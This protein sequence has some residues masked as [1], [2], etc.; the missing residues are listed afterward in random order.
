MPFSVFGG[1][2]TLPAQ[3]SYASYSFAAS[4]TLLWPT[5]MQDTSYP[6]AFF[7]DVSASAGGLS[8]TMPNATQASPG[9]AVIF[10]NYGS[11]SISVLDAASGS[12]FT[13]A[14][15]QARYLVL[16][17]NATAAGS[18][19]IVTFGTGTSSADASALA[20]RG[21]QAISGQL[22]WAPNTSSSS[23][24]P[25]TVNVSDRCN[26]FIWTGGAGTMNLPGVA[27]AGDRFV[28]AVNNQGSG[29]LTI[30][31][32]GA[33]TIDGAA[34]ITLNPGQSCFIVCY[35]GASWYTIGR[36]V[37]SASAITTLTKNV[38]GGA[39]TYTL[40][41]SE[42]A[43]QIQ[44]FTGAITGN[45]II[46]YGS[47][48]NYYFV[49]NNTSGAFTVTFRGGGADPGVVVASGT[50]A[51]IVNNAGTMS[52]AVTVAAGTVTNIATAAGRLTGGP[53]TTTGTLDLATTAVTPGSYGSTTA[54]STFTVDAYGRLTAASAVSLAAAGMPVMIGDSG[55][56]GTQGAVPAPGAGDAAAGKFLGA[57]GTWSVPSGL[58]TLPV[59]AVLD[60]G[61]STLP[62]GF[63]WPAG[64]NVSRTTYA[65]L[66]AKYGTTFGAGDGSTTF[67]MPDLRGRVAVGKD[68]MN[69][70]A[71]NRVTNAISGITGTTLGSAGGSQSMTAHIHTFILNSGLGISPGASGQGGSLSTGNT[72]STGAGASEN[73]PPSLILN[74][75]VY[76]GV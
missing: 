39:A 66:F 18:W 25:I 2:P 9:Q 14:A 43:A 3:V 49:Y 68:D 76:A 37:T 26:L 35:N 46:E 56:G 31:P 10:Y 21:I 17:S 13:L 7:I 16:T 27:A 63:L 61:G 62:A 72:G 38:A 74:K 4:I 73:M 55:A 45:I 1:S 36:A 8:I 24:S 20:G 12:L 6:T 51:I 52:V 33:E 57:G 54:L 29:I 48:S 53:I 64:Q 19:R 30:D 70:S 15:G 34:T 22:S 50:R 58:G 41:T 69:G 40:T 47:T 5:G 42:I 11:N 67:G 65:A 60:Y 59:G 32:S 75:I 44:S 23:S 28:I 71:A